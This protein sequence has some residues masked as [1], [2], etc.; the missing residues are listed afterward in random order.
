MESAIYVTFSRLIQLNSKNA[1]ILK[2]IHKYIYINMYECISAVIRDIYAQKNSKPNPT[3]IT[4]KKESK[5]S[6]FIKKNGKKQPKIV[7]LIVKSSFVSLKL[8]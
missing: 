5:K 2:C 6:L 1:Y 4:L 3:F 8:F 7:F